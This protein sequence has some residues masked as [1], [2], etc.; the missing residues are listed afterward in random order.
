MKDAGGGIIVNVLSGGEGRAALRSSRMGLLGLTLEL[1]DEF[2]AYNI[3]VN[4]VAENAL[5]LATD[6][7]VPTGD[8]MDMVTAALYLCSPEAENVSGKILIAQ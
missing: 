1:A 2:S 6:V 7:I 4:A 5:G 8:P 3:R